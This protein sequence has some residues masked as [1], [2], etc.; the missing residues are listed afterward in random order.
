MK[1]IKL[2]EHNDHEGETWRFWLQLD[3]NEEE[4]HKLQEF[5]KEHD[6]SEEFALYTKEIDE[7]E[8][9]ILVK[10]TMSGYMDYDNKLT[11]TFTMK[12]LDTSELDDEDEIYESAL[13]L[14]YKGAVEEMFK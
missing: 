13:E 5:I 14:L 10:H 11:G 8:V 6:L 9:D 12:E 4:L 7:S 3:G 1:F 2:V